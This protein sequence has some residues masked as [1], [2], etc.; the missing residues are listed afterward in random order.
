MIVISPSD[1]KIFKYFLYIL[2][3]VSVCF[4]HVR[5]RFDAALTA[6]KKDFTKRTV[7]GNSYC[8][9]DYGANKYPV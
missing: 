1:R 7:A 5:R 8:V 9:P 6:L 3:L 4:T 2:A